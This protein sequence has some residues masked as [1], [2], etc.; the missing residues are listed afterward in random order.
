L[1][2]EILRSWIGSAVGD[3][4][5]SLHTDPDSLEHPVNSDLIVIGDLFRIPEYSGDALLRAVKCQV[6][7]TG[8]TPVAVISDSEGFETGLRC[9][10]SGARGFIPTHSSLAV[11]VAALRLILTGGVYVPFE[12]VG[13]MDGRRVATAPTAPRQAA[14]P[15]RGRFGTLPASELSRLGLSRRET[16]ILGY[17]QQGSGNKQIAETLGISDNTVMVHMRNLMRKLGAT[18]RAQAVF[19]ARQ[20]L[21][22]A[23]AQPGA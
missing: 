17:L 20:K 8:E 18:N 9:L 15:D 19:K 16:Q 11:T 22:S 21:M 1:A 12:I 14:T 6:G 13:D 5:I 2:A 7:P 23:A 10:Q 3:C 4:N